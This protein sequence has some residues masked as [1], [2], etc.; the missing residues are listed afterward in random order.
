[1]QAEWKLVN[2]LYERARSE[3]DR[4]NYEAAQDVLTDLLERTDNVSLVQRARFVLGESYERMG[5]YGE[6]YEQY[7]A[8]IRE[9]LGAS[10]RIVERA[11][12]RIDAFR[13]AG[14]I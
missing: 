1:M 12:A 14:L 5:D 4:G 11:R 3:F 10:G 9:D 8:I 7:K 2:L 13:D 6:A